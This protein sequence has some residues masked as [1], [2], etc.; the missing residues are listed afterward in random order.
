MN[1]GESIKKKNLPHAPTIFL[2]FV[3]PVASK[4]K[5]N[6]LVSMNFDTFCGEVSGFWPL[7]GAPDDTAVF[8]RQSRWRREGL[9]VSHPATIH[10]HDICKWVSRT[11]RQQ[12]LCWWPAM[13]R[14]LVQNRVSG[15]L[16]LFGTSLVCQAGF[17]FCGES[18]KNRWG[19]LR[20]R[21]RASC[22]VFARLGFD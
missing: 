5:W 17:F 14:S 11:C 21:P 3:S 20:I 13:S 1:S 15:N 8:C 16:S 10:H 12:S 6:G 19:E 4:V 9:S 2:Q 7:L 18:A 22:V